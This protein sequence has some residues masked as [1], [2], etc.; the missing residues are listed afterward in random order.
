VLTVAAALSTIVISIAAPAHATCN[1][2]TKSEFRNTIKVHSASLH[3]T[4][5]ISPPHIEGTV[6]C[7]TIG[8]QSLLAVAQR[9]DACDR[10]ESS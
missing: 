6:N 2:K 8:V 10:S 5:A 7:K 1:D 9:L 3:Q 4:Q